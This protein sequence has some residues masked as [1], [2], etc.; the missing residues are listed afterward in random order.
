MKFF[1]FKD[2]REK[3]PD[4]EATKPDDWDENEP[5]QIVDTEA[6]MPSDWLVNEPLTIADPNAV[7]PDD[8]DD[9]VD[10]EWEA[11]RIDN[12]LCASG[13]CGEWKPP[14]IDNPKYKGKWS[15]PLIA[16]PNF[17]GI[18]APRKIPNP[19]YFEDKNPFNSLKSFSVLG[20]ELWSMT[21]NIYFDNFLITDDE[22]VA[23][24][25]AKNSWVIKKS[26]KPVETK[27][28]EEPANSEGEEEVGEDEDE[29]SNLKDEL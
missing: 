11:A 15:A 29:S 7:K 9:E 8:W 10:G 1:F 20:L 22:T 13:T 2:E 16:N 19:A 24:E 28:P 6:V 14:M 23:N 17:Q 12:P 4:L 25:F 5:K 18:W 3:I 26:V 27:K 21:E